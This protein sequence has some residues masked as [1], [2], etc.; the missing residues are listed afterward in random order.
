MCGFVD[1]VVGCETQHTEVI[2]IDIPHRVNYSTKQS[3]RKE[4]ILNE[5]VSCLKRHNAAASHPDIPVTRPATEG[6]LPTT[7]CRL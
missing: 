6:K 2:L 1:L 7:L 5:L 3:V 4:G